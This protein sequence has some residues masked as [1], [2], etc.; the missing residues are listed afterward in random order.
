MEQF[1]KNKGLKTSVFLMLGLT[2]FLVGFI[3]YMV[4]SNQKFFDSKYSLYLF[5]SKAEALNPGAFVTL[6]GLKIGVVGDMKFTQRNNQQGILVELKID[7]DYAKQITHSSRATI[8][9][10]G[11]LGDKYVDISLGSLSEPPLQPGDFVRSKASVDVSALL[12]D[13]ASSLTELNALLSNLKLLSQQMLKGQG[14][15]G[16]LVSDKK[17]ATDFNNIVHN[18]SNISEELN[19]GQGNAGKLLQDSL[20]YQ[21]LLNTSK[22]L[23]VITGHISEGKGAVGKLVADT[24]LYPRIQSIAIQSDSLLKKL[25]GNGTMGQLLKDKKLYDEFFLL[26]RELRELTNDIKEHPKKYG[27]FSIF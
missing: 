27:S 8:K 10:M 25:Q 1:D 13:A 24:T 2:L 3:F 19:H 12:A 20:L 26:T 23:D 5:L 16:R 9:T 17:M 15:V 14:T 21:S 6:S 11:I 4:G 7:K 22:Q 18:F